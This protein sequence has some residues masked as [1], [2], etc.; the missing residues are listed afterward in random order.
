MA[1]RVILFVTI[2]ALVLCNI[3]LMP[4]TVRAEAYTET[5]GLFLQTETYDKGSALVK[6]VSSAKP[7][8]INEEITGINKY[9]IVENAWDFG[10]AVNFAGST[11]QKS[12]FKDKSMY[13]VKVS[14]EKYT[15]EELIKEIA[16]QEN[17]L[18]VQPDYCQEKT[19]IGDAMTDLQWY[20]DGNNVTSEGINYSK[21]IQNEETDSET[22]VVAVL[23]T[24][25]DYTHE[26]L[27]GNMW[28]NT[29]SSLKGV[30]GYDFGD[31]DSNPMDIDGHGTHCAGIIGAET[32]N[33]VGIAGVETNVRLMAL[34]IFSSDGKVYNSAIIGALNY[35]YQ[36]QQLGE[37]IVAVNCSWG[38]GKSDSM[39]QT[40][41]NQIGAEGALFIFAAGN[42]AVNHDDFKDKEC[43]YDIN[44]QYIIV[45]GASDMNDKKSAFSDFGNS[46]V[47]IFA[48]GS[49]ILSTVCN[50]TFYPA[51]LP[52]SQRENICSYFFSCDS[53]ALTDLS[54][55]YIKGNADA[56]DIEYSPED[57]FGNSNSGSMRLKLSGDSINR[58]QDIPIGKPDFSKGGFAL[59]I[60]ASSIGLSA[61]DKCYVGFDIGINGNDGEIS[62]SHEY[63]E[64][65]YNS[66]L[67][68]NGKVWLKIVE[69]SS[70]DSFSDIYFDNLSVSKANPSRNVLCRY[71]IYDG[72]SM[73]APVVSAAVAL[74][75]SVHTDDSSALRFGRLLNCV[76][77]TNN[78]LG[79]CR[80]SGILDIS[81][82]PDAE[83]TTDFLPE[84][85][86]SG[87]DKENSGTISDVVSGNNNTS[88]LVPQDSFV[89][90]T[91]TGITL[92][93]IDTAIDNPVEIKKIKLNKK[94]VVLHYKGK[95]KCKLK[96]TIKPA[97]ATCQELKWYV[98]KRYRKY[99]V[100]SPS[101]VI[102]AKKKGIG[103]DVIVFAKAKDGSGTIA[104]C[105]VKIRK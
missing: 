16:V 64:R 45:V 83:Y 87:S 60:D 36:A 41:I 104:Y 73:A 19:D 79:Y 34:K 78:L 52:E 10:D 59:Y 67:N 96:A 91:N 38:G 89:G 95:S 37:N 13:V 46:T 102:W 82:I 29:H 5:S 100:V 28:V 62:W 8:Q 70:A 66:Y 44:S 30:Y 24:G 20:L 80:T 23:D 11:T 98:E 65:S 54:S 31:N 92:L 6:I 75:S 21:L 56:N 33:G 7:S 71:N 39:M 88:G 61:A 32:N 97:K 27:A 49:R 81:K 57:S 99:I 90:Y 55:F 74:L 93:P 26:D 18:S 103:H 25:I 22:P 48:P 3:N 53:N 17:V 86:G 51:L 2:A 9:I 58:W 69:I 85:P 40:L 77:K 76:R 4:T 101:G 35:I 47:D 15:T 72:T 43:P 1:K 105:K 84:E 68:Y 94:K 14:S 50:D 12:S 42:D 63:F